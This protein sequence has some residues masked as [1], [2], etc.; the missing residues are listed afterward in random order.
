[1]V[2]I[3]ADS[4]FYLAYIGDLFRH[5][6]DVNVRI[7]KDKR[8]RNTFG[9]IIQNAAV[10]WYFNLLGV[11]IGK[12]KALVIPR[13]LNSR[14]LKMNFIAGLANTDGH[15]DHNRIHLKQK[16]KRFLKSLR[17]EL[18]RLRMNCSAPKVNYTNM[19]PFYY[20]R[21]DNKIPLR[22]ASV[23]QW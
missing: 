10:F 6:F 3:T 22:Y 13:A 9:L 17:I 14:K 12:K 2:G 21:F 18:N 19:V 7:V 11:P 15:V 5:Y 16:D 23:A 4:E 20:I 1:M 8:K